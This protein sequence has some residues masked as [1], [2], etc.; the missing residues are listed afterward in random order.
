MTLIR[1]YHETMT[2]KRNRIANKAS[3][4]KPDPSPVSAFMTKTT[5]NPQSKPRPRSGVKGLIDL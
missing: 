2:Q 3:L 4:L 1:K 5:L